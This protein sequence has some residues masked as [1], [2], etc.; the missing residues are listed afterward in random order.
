MSAN[1]K[2]T[3]KRKPEAALPFHDACAVFPEMEGVEF[4]ELVADIKRRG[5]RVPITTFR[6][7]IPRPDGSVSVHEMRTLIIDGRNRARA[8][9]EAGVTPRYEEFDG[10]ADDV[11]R[12]IISANIHR[13]NLTADDRRKYLKQLIE[14][15]PEKSDRTIAAESGFGH[16]TVSRARKSTVS[17]ETV[18]KRT[19]R[20]GKTRRMPTPKA[21][22]EPEQ[23]TKTAIAAA[24]SQKMP[25]TIGPLPNGSSY[26][27]REIDIAEH[28]EERANIVIQALIDLAFDDD[29]TISKSELL[30]AVLELL[31]AN[32]ASN[33]LQLARRGIGFV[34]LIEAALEAINNPR[35]K[36]N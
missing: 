36:P 30:T 11:I 28:V 6:E 10:D 16:A 22:P 15:N 24:A 29:M 8:C 4:D 27:V 17:P 5:L 12:F 14:W 34:H 33:N 1:N 9:A 20:D 25:G 31:H 35:A 19:G 18:G 13:R 23:P 26:T 3:K 21:K 2:P 32:P 7:P